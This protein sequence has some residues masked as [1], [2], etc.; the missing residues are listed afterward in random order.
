MRNLFLF[1][2]SI[3]IFISCNKDESVIKDSVNEE[4]TLLKIADNTPNKAMWVPRSQMKSRNGESMGYGV[5]LNPTS[6]KLLIFLD[7]GGA[8]FNQLT[9]FQNLDLYSE[10]DFS[11]RIA[12]DSSLL[13]NRSSDQNQFKDWNMVFV[14]YAT[15]DVH[16]GT[17]SSAN[18]PYNGPKNQSMVGYT[19]FSIILEDLK[20]YFDS[21]GQVTEIVF[22]GSSAGGYGVMSNTFQLTNILAMNTPTTVIV[23]ASPIFM[24]ATIY[25]H[26]LN[27][28]WNSDSLWNV[29]S[30]LPS[31]LDEIVQNNYEYNL[32]K[33]YEY[34]SL[35]LHNVNFGLLSYY[36]DS[37]ISSF[38]SFG[39]N[40]CAYPPNSMIGTNDFKFGLLE[41]KTT[42][43]DNLDNWKV[44][45]ANGTEH[46][47]LS[48]ANF[49]QTI[50][51]TKLNDWILQLRQ[52]KAENLTE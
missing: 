4:L 26:C 50:K 23:D 35:K 49:D 22:T 20:N 28:L 24:D 13:I 17:N 3:T 15:G 48:D 19:N 33:L 38:Y 31:D 52:G 34:L 40:N 10:E 32:Q 6:N 42:V 1:L 9:C 12:S 47:F 2:F 43:L 29:N 21:A 30:A 7:G 41:L 14:P 5:I 11:N 44:F 51:D 16:S 25:T 46:T 39:K 27:D 36:G 45:Y 8:C 18:V 37:V